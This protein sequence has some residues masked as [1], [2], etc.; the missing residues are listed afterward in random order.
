MVVDIVPVVVDIVPV[1]V[2]IV[3]VVGFLSHTDLSKIVT[4]DKKELGILM[5]SLRN[6]R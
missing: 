1:M 4:M 5:S 2:D 3:P 6:T